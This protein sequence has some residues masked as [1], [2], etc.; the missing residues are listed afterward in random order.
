VPK[1]LRVKDDKREFYYDKQQTQLAKIVGK[2]HFE[3]DIY[4]FA[5]ECKKPILIKE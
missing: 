2:H 4:D 3:K 5:K 1:V